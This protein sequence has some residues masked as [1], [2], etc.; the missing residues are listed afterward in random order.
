MHRHHQVILFRHLEPP[1]IRCCN[2]KRPDDQGRKA[3][4]LVVRKVSPRTQCLASS[5]SSESSRV[6]ACSRAFWSIQKALWIELRHIVAPDGL[7][8]V[9]GT[10]CN[11]DHATFL[12]I[13]FVVQN[14]VFLDQPHG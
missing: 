8:C 2:L 9:N 5:K 3:E 13:V 7:V 11:L 12:E 14:H 4:D 10:T 1:A 6:K